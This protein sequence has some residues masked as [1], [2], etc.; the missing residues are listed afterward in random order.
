MLGV[1]AELENLSQQK[2]L[3]QLFTSTAINLSTLYRSSANNPGHVKLRRRTCSHYQQQVCHVRPTTAPAA[4]YAPV[5]ESQKPL[6]DS[7]RKL[8]RS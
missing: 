8:P 4:S 7:S 6:E 5:E 3:H 2:A 1:D